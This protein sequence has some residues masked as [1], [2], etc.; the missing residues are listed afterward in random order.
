M[1]SVATSRVSPLWLAQR[2]SPD[3][4]ARARD[5]VH[6]LRPRLRRQS[7]VVHDFGCGTGSMTR[8]LAPQLPGPQHWILYDTDPSL[9]VL[10]VARTA[11]LTGSDGSSVTVETRTVDITL[12]RPT[13]IEPADLVTGSALLDLLTDRE[14]KDLIQTC[15]DVRCPVLFSLTVTGRICLTPVDPLD[16]VV[17]S[18][19]NA[20]QRRRTRGGRLMGPDASWASAL[21]FHRSGA[22]LHVQ[23]S[24]WILGPRDA[25]LIA[26]WFAGWVAAAREMQPEISSTWIATFAGVTPT[27]R[28]ADCGW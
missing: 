6:I 3:A 25:D 9:L 24:P 7:L 16:E 27:W 5:L 15:V 10:A 18:A 19:F 1:T 4:A 8:W 22:E 13:E 28:T 14:M 20:H 23:A 26:P 17:R 11:G 12:L 2:E 21:W